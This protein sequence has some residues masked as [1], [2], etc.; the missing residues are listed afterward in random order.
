MGFL[1]LP[2]HA[3]SYFVLQQWILNVHLAP[4]TPSSRWWDIDSITSQGSLEAEMSEE[5][6][7]V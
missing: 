3:S 7:E 5:L 1:S 2:V 6:Q 4:H